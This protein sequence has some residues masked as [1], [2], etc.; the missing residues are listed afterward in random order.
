MAISLDYQLVYYRRKPIRIPL[1]L[2]IVFGVILFVTASAKITI[3]NA[4]TDL[5]YK[6]AQQREMTVALD[7]QRRELE[8]E[9]SV[10][11]KHDILASRARTQLALEPL[12]PAQARK[13]TY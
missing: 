3:S 4:S 1:R 13:L 6:I 12:K 2:V 8:L 7:M 9:R 11:L 5:G 10:L